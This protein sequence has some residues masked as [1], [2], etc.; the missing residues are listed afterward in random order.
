MTWIRH[1][2]LT[3]CNWV[4]IRKQHTQPQSEGKKNIVDFAKLKSGPSLEYFLANKTQTE[5]T[6]IDPSPNNVPYLDPNLFRV[7]SKTVYFETYGCQMNVNDTE[8]VWSILKDSGYAKTDD[9]RSAD[10]VFLMTCAIR[11]GAEQKIRKRLQSLEALKTGRDAKVGVLGCMAER[12]K[13]KLVEEAKVVD[14]VCGP[15][16]YRDLPRMLATTPSGHAGVNV[17]L[18]LDETYADVMPVRLNETGKS[19]FVSIMR[20]CDNMCTYCIVPFTRGRE[21]SRPIKSIVEEVKQLRDQGVR[22]I[23]LLGQNVNS[24]RDSS[25][26]VEGLKRQTNLSNQGFRTVYKPKHGGL[27]FSELLDQVSLVDPEMRIRFTS[28]HPKDF[29]A[30]LLDLIKERTNV[31]NYIHLP[32][33]SGNNKVL[34]SMR[35]GYTREAYLELVEDIRARIPDIRLSSDFI[36]GFCGET[37]EAH[38]QTLDLIRRVKY[39]FCFTFPY[40]MREKTGAHRRLSDDVSEDVKKRRHLELS[41]AFREEALTVNRE[42]IGERH[43]V[44]VEGRS[45]KSAEALVGRNDGF[46]K[47][48]FP[49]TPIPCIDSNVESIPAPGSY[50]IVEILDATSMTLIG[51]PLI[52]TTLALSHKYCDNEL[53]SVAI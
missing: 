34:E 30:E 44:L 52:Q 27:R 47:V 9:A 16:A 51:Q 8:I 19:A 3:Y 32:A 15:D 7:N 17:L 10:V 28:P 2:I 13:T 22:E 50:V 42:Q 12:L 40:S 24:Y 33:Q 49:K 37:E 23:T 53:Q 29:P 5:S 6:S 36:A 14:V 39:S 35:R 11:E 25:E 21:R 38:E 41:S 46:V 31:C 4:T 43:V 20:G 48:V 1:K 45:K 18:S 26:N